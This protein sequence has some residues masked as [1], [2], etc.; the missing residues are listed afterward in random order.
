MSK[1]RAT[2]LA[3]FGLTPK[4]GESELLL[5]ERLYDHLDGLPVADGDVLYEKLD[6]AAQDFYNAIGDNKTSAGGL[7]AKPGTYG[8]PWPDAEAAAP[9]AAGRSRTRAAAPAPAP[10]PEPAYVPAVGDI[11]DVE[12]TDGRSYTAAEVLEVN[13][14]DNALWLKV[15]GEAEDVDVDLDTSTVDLHVEPPA[16]E[17]APQPAGRSRSR[18]AAAPAP[19]A[20]E[21]AEPAE[22]AL[23]DTVEVVTGR[24]VTVLGKVTFLG[25]GLIELTKA[26]G[27]VSEFSVATLKSVKVKVQAKPAASPAAPAGRSRGGAAAAPAAAAEGTTRAGRAANGGVSVGQRIRE[28]IIGNLDADV[29]KIGALAKAEKLEFKDNTLALTYNE[30]HKL[31]AMLRERKLMK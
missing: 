3:T 16:P 27:G 14:A 29:A 26:D 1:I 23:D 21:P 28:L 6:A 8:L 9:A 30:A 15:E 24:G 11:V 2:M 19:A 5:A 31:I 18:G 4:R 13:E 22:P 17:P 20:S 12:T 7:D 10:E 25:D